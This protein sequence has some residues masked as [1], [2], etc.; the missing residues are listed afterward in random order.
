MLP[1]LHPSAVVIKA[2]S[3]DRACLSLPYERDFL[4]CLMKVF[5]KQLSSMVMKM[6]ANVVVDDVVVVDVVVVDVAVNVV[7]NMA[8]GSHFE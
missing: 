1:I 4:D 7:V 2:L 6:I 5:G 3:F 8:V